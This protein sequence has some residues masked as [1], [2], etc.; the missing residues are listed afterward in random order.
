[1]AEEIEA[2][3]QLELLNR[4]QD[5][6]KVTDIMQD[7]DAYIAIYKQALD[8][9]AKLRAIQNRLLAKIEKQKSI[10]QQQA[11]AAQGQPQGA[12]QSQNMLMSNAMQ[13]KKSDP[14]VTAKDVQPQ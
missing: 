12:A 3:Q 10:A 5:V 13:Q 14:V 2:R 6:D 8:T 11:A 4:N 9:P 1:M 7:H